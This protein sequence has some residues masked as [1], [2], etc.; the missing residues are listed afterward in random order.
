MASC[1]L[2]KKYI[3]E[4]YEYSSIISEEFGDNN[5][6]EMKTSASTT[7]INSRNYDNKSNIR[8]L[9]NQNEKSQMTRSLLPQE[10]LLG[11]NYN[12][13]NSHSYLTNKSS[14]DKKF[15]R[16][17]SSASLPSYS[18]Q[19]NKSNYELYENKI[20][21][22][23]VE[24]INIDTSSFS[25]D[26]IFG[27][28]SSSSNY[29]TCS[30]SLSSS[31]SEV[32]FSFENSEEE[33][34]E[35]FVPF[36]E[37][38][39]KRKFDQLPKE[40]LNNVMKFLPTKSLYNVLFVNRYMYNCALPYLWKN[41]N[42]QNTLSCFKFCTNFENN[43]LY[44]NNFSLYTETFNICFPNQGMNLYKFLLDK[45]IINC[46]NIKNVRVSKS[47]YWY[48]DKTISLFTKNCKNLERIRY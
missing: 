29:L 16:V 3:N 41:L 44:K 28:S 15:Y 17:S 2:L 14:Y 32:N 39:K 5:K 10:I 26:S 7:C 35:V 18:S 9:N 40:V 30:S 25:I 1:N 43:S 36:K 42:F 8:N 13:N 45:I 47:L 6:K 12:R 11:L 21:S 23:S 31:S 37:I 27:S 4:C 48:M 46:R 33:K 20:G 22:A 19:N 38:Q 34:T 24:T